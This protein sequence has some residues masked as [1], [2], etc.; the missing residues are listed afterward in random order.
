[1]ADTYRCDQPEYTQ[2]LDTRILRD[3]KASRHD[4]ERLQFVI[5]A[6]D[7]GC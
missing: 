3:Q 1:M 5:D 7:A 4:H 6:I 2:I